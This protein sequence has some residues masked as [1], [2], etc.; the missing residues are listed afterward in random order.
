MKLFQGDKR[1]IKA[2]KNMVASFFLKG[3]DGVIYLA[4]VPLTLGFLDPY[5]YGL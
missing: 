5:S 3:L 4:V 2:K 1:T